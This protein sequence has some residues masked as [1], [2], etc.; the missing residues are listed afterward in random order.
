MSVAKSTETIPL[1]S[2]KIFTKLE[3]KNKQRHKITILI[4]LL[5]TQEMPWDVIIFAS[6]IANYDWQDYW[7]L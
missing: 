5:K 2:L 1:T 6:N 4:G 3:P 7:I